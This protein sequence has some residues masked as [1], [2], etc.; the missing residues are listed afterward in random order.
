MY[1]RFSN[2][3]EDIKTQAQFDKWVEAR[4]KEMKEL[5]YENRRIIDKRS[6]EHELDNFDS[7]KK[8][9]KPLKDLRK[10]SKVYDALFSIDREGYCRFKVYFPITDKELDE[11]VEYRRKRV[12]ELGRW[13]SICLKPEEACWTILHERVYKTF[14]FTRPCESLQY[15]DHPEGNGLI[16]M[17][18]V[19]SFK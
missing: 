1:Y 8:A 15:F 2:L 6:L 12:A 10:K 11:C 16:R 9:Y 13:G 18:E 14:S 5:A 7:V 3:V 4:K 17:M 19:Y